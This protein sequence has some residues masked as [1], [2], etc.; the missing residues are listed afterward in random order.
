MAESSRVDATNAN[1]WKQPFCKSVI[2]D[3]RSMVVV[4][5]IQVDIMLLGILIQR[6]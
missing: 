5:G 3:I 1:S 2:A 6:A 4:V